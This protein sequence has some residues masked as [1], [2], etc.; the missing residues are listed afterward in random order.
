LLAPDSRYEIQVGLY[1]PVS[2][3]RLPLLDPV[4]QRLQDDR[5]VA[6]V[7]ETPKYRAL[8]PV[9]EVGYEHSQ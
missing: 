3:R 6:A 1:D 7:I 2:G 9:V 5:M 4:G 8:F